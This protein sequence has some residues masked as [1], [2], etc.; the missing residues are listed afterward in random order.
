MKKLFPFFLLF[1]SLFSHAQDADYSNPIYTN[2]IPFSNQ[3]AQALG[4]GSVGVVSPDSYQGTAI[5]HNPSLLIQKPGYLNLLYSHKFSIFYNSNLDANVFYSPDTVNSFAIGF[6]RMSYEEF[7]FIDNEGVEQSLENVYNELISLAYARKISP[8]WSLGLASR[9][10]MDNM[11]YNYSNP[12]PN[13][14][15]L[16]TFSINAGANYSRNFRLSKKLACKLQWGASLNNLGPKYGYPDDE[17]TFFHSTEI[18][19]GILVG[20]EYRFSDKAKLSLNLAYQAGKYLV[21]SPPVYSPTWEILIGRDPSEVS[22]FEALYQSF[23]DAPYGFKEE[24]SEINH[25]F[26]A[27]LSYSYNDFLYLAFRGGYNYSHP[28]KGNEKAGTFGVAIGIAGFTLSY[29]EADVFLFDQILTLS[30]QSN[31]QK[32]FRF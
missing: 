17:Y 24:L 2:Y 27:E 19:T 12:D 6:Y 10:Y 30:Y 32:L 3:T 29:S 11:Y 31:I 16:T 23:Y 25:N 20:P 1:V 18:L 26:G 14:T 8:Y 4:F 28:W 21:P 7:N 13:P 22:V 5:T 15:P 9:I